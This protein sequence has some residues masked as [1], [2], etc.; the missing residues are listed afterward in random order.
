VADTVIVPVARSPI[1]PAPPVAVVAGWEVSAR[2][3]SA[4]LRLVDCTPLAKVLVR[5]ALE[6]AGSR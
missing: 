4:P 6:E 2:R 3:S 1:A 5:R